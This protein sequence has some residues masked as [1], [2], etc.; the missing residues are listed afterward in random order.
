MSWSITPLAAICECCLL[1]S[2]GGGLLL[3]KTAA[4]QLESGGRR[5]RGRGGGGA[6]G[7]SCSCVRLRLLRTRLNCEEIHTFENNFLH[8]VACRFPL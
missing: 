6:E 8:R 4:L 2:L 7:S 3:I 1:L 5:G